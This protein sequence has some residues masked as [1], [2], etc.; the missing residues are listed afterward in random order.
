MIFIARFAVSKNS[1]QRYEKN[2]IYAILGHN[3]YKIMNNCYKIQ[4]KDWE[5][6]QSFSIL[7]VQIISHE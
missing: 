2:R 5:Y 7:I 6:T 4:K 3:F 1:A